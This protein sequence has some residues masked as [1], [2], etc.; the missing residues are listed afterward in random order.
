MSKGRRNIASRRAL[1][2][3][4]PR[5]PA[6][7][8]IHDGLPQFFL[9]DS[10]SMKYIGELDRSQNIL[11]GPNLVEISVSFTLCELHLVILLSVLRAIYYGCIL[12]NL[13]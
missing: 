5:I 10:I 3:F 9:S 6:G 8:V 2:L 12:I 11:H 7:Y 1:R 13:V 4:A